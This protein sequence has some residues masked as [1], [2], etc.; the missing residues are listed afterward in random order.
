VK[1]KHYASV[2]ELIAEI[3]GMSIE[4]LASEPWDGPHLI[5]VDELRAA[6]ALD[7]PPAWRKSL[8]GER[9]LLPLFGDDDAGAE[10]QPPMRIDAEDDV[11]ADELR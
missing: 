8:G 2:D 3:A 6:G 5:T 11:P 9:D 1:D 7:V 4:E 10:Q